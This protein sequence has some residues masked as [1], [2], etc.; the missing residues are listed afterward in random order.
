MHGGGPGDP[1]CDLPAL[2]IAEWQDLLE[3]IAEKTDRI[4]EKIK[5]LKAHAVEIDTARCLQT[6]LGG[7]TVLAVEAFAPEM[8]Q[9][10]SRRDRARPV[11]VH[12]HNGRHQPRQIAPVADR[13]TQ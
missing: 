5:S 1:H 13:M 2:I 4:E 12:P 10:K 6:M 7:L 11:A 8:A 3:E 9:F